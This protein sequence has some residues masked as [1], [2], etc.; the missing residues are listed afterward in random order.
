[1]EICKWYVI[2]QWL[3]GQSYDANPII[4]AKVDGFRVCGIPHSCGVDGVKERPR[5]V[6]GDTCGL[7]FETSGPS[8]GRRLWC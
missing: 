1:M 2:H 7:Y 6:V 8:F 4:C 5:L 3:D